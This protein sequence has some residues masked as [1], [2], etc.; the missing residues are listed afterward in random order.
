MD[1]LMFQAADF[2][3]IIR[4]TPDADG[5]PGFMYQ[6]TFALTVR[7]LR[8]DSRNL[9]PH[10][11]RAGLALFILMYLLSTQQSSTRQAPGRDL[12][13]WIIYT[14]AV[15]ASFVV[16]LL[17]ANAITEEKEERTLSLLLIADVSPLALLIGKFLPR[18]LSVLLVFVIQLPFSLLAITLGGVTLTQV[19]AGYAAVA[20]YVVFV[21]LMSLWCS[22]VL[23]LTANAIGLAGLMLLA[24]H[25]F[26]AILHM[27]FAIYANDR[28]W[29]EFAQS[30]LS[31]MNMY[32]PTNL[33]FRLNTILV[34]GYDSGVLSLQVGIN[35]IF[36]LLFFLTAWWMFPFSN[37]EMDATPVKR[38]SRNAFRRRPWRAAIAWKEFY[39]TAGG[40]FQFWLKLVLYGGVFLLVTL[41]SVNWNWNRIDWSESTL[42]GAGVLFYFFLPLETI[43]TVGRLFYPEIK[44]QTLSSLFMLPLS[45]ARIAYS[46]LF[47]ALLS[48]LPACF[49][50]SLALLFNLKF[51]AEVI[52]KLDDFSLEVWLI[53]LNVGANALFYLNLV[54]W[55]STRM[56]SW[57]AMIV[58]SFIH[59]FGVIS[60]MLLGSV[61]V[62]VLDLQL[63]DW[64]GYAVEF[65]AASIV[66]VIAT[67]LHINI[68]RQLEMK[69]AEA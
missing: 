61:F 34:A 18:M 66:L 69:A 49:W 35:L 68:A 2:S 20:A 27:F 36:G 9:T 32:W 37:R 39:F 56:N 51:L 33:F 62:M 23:R 60:V 22:F 64:F 19:I 44:D 25:A 48:L 67:S 53:L 52:S 28:I 7:A 57:W 1:A 21:G 41:A 47:G 40:T 12:F 6:K 65:A 3:I 45:T 59:Y 42:I 43:L 16:P 17:F 31:T 30:G 14:N 63:P 15:F 8:V 24:Y 58:A 10:L 46:K 38:R 26:P 11:L 5:S 13:G 29:G 54:A 55:L 50:L 4:F